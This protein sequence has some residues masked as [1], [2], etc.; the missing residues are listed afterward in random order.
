[1]GIIEKI[2]ENGLKRGSE[3]FVKEWW[4]KNKFFFWVVIG[5][6]LL[7]S[8]PIFPLSETEVGHLEVPIVEDAGYPAYGI[9]VSSQCGYLKHVFNEKESIPLS[10]PSVSNIYDV[11][12][13]PVLKYHFRD[14]DI[15]IYAI[16]SCETCINDSDVMLLESKTCIMNGSSVFGYF[17]KCVERRTSPYSIQEECTRTPFMV[18]DN[19]EIVSPERDFKV[20]LHPYVSK[21]KQQSDHKIEIVRNYQVEVIVTYPKFKPLPY[22][23]WLGTAILFVLDPLKSI[24]DYFLERW[25]Y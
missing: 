3:I 10:K 23:K 13:P 1:M 20:T 7:T 17:E 12:D 15:S 25:K 21:A 19:L 8:L 18:S 22:A 5:F 11:N 9:E 2:K 14:Y 6:I 16:K 24:F 4:K